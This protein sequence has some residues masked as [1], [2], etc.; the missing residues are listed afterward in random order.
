MS[1]YSKLPSTVLALIQFIRADRPAFCKSHSAECGQGLGRPLRLL[2]SV[3]GKI[4][5]GCTSVI[6]KLLNERNARPPPIRNLVDA[7]PVFLDSSWQ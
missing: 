7:I 3:T 5:P 6:L 4:S 1:N 2:A